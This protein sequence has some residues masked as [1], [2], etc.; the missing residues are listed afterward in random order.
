M[1]NMVNMNTDLQE[2]P[3]FL[4]SLSPSSWPVPDD[5]SFNWSIGLVKKPYA[6][7]EKAAPKCDLQISQPPNKGFHFT[8]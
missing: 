2:S 8:I 7:P 5:E 6:M 1:M 4:T 3:Y